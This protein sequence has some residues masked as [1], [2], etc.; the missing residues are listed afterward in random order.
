[1]C[2]DG[3]SCTLCSPSYFYSN[4]SCKSNGNGMSSVI[5]SLGNIF[6]CPIG[7]DSCNLGPNGI[8][9]CNAITK[10]YT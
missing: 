4:N 2:L 5:D 3:T 1:M 10:G 8:L 7:C 9:I 6:T